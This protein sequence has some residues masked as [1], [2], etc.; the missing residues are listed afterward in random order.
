MFILQCDLIRLIGAQSPQ[1]APV[2]PVWAVRH[3]C[4]GFGSPV[5]WAPSF[6]DSKMQ[7]GTGDGARRSRVLTTSSIAVAMILLQFLEVGSVR[8]ELADK[9]HCQ[10]RVR[11]ASR[12]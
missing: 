6:G 8:L 11:Q 7:S 5:G 12:S 2:S 9:A 1:Q 3:G 10:S 4:C